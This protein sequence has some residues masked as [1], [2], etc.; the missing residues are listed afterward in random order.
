MK[1]AVLRGPKDI[2][3]L[4]IP[5]WELPPDMVMLAVNAC[6][7]CGSDL[8]YYVGENPWALHTLGRAVPNPPNIVLGHEFAGE[9]VEVGSRADAGLLGKRVGA[10][11]YNTC[12]TCAYCRSGRENLCPDTVHI[13]HGAGWGRMPFFP[14]A[15][16][17]LCPVWSRQCYELP[18][19]LSWEEAAL[20]DPLQVAVHAVELSGLRPGATFAVFGLGPIGLCAIQ[21]ARAYGALLT[22][23]TD[24]YAAPLEMAREVGASLALDARDQ[25]PVR[26]IREASGGS[27]ADVLI[28]TVGSPRSLRDGLSALAR[29]GT[30]V[31]LAVHGGEYSFDG[32]ALGSERSIRTSS[33]SL[34]SDYGKAIRLAASGAV[35]LSVMITHRYPLNEVPNAFAL[36][37]EKERHGAVKAI[38]QPTG[39]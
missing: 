31:N 4:D 13:G 2:A 5:R 15:M 12:G 27:G 33:N 30:L 11:A 7:V 37:L 20:L 14:G 39:G 28:D 38:I 18:E 36:L 29:S 8:R 21:V 22:V 23:G 35:N 9:V 24:I 16:A 3:V 19:N 1:A 10:L 25:D 34:F 32:L 26:A 17:E 6:G